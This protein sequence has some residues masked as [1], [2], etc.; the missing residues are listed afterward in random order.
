M[1]G[2]IFGVL[3]GVSAPA[4]GQVRPAPA[5][6]LHGQ[7]ITPDMRNPAAGVNIKQ[8]LGDQLPLDT[9]FQ[10]DTGASVRLGDYF[11]NERPV[12]LAL[13]YFECPMLCSQL[14]QNLVSNLRAITR[15]DAGDDFEIVIISI[16]HDEEVELAARA[17]ATYTKRYS[18]KGTDDGWHFL[19]GERVE[20]DRVCEAVG[21][22]FRYDPEIDE[23]AHAAGIQVCTASG[24]LS[25]YYYGTDF[26]AIDL[27]LGLVD[28]SEG[29]VGDLADEILLLCLSYDPTTGRYGLVIMNVIRFL[30]ALTFLLI[31]SFVGVHLWRER[32]QRR[33][34]EP[35]HR[36]PIL[37]D[38]PN[39]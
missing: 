12:I 35:G 38:Q 30:G 4:S 13:V 32:K 16:D 20:I 34:A 7:G 22:T 25:R 5:P 2:L 37:K 15:Y 23:Y 6:G 1:L 28:A 31:V 24:V 26:P 36:M 27:Q 3:V 21:Y 8:H 10:D 9:Q 39:L 18:R 14:M 11:G 17:K 33:R 19:V 29:T